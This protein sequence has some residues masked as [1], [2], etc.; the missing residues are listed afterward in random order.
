MRFETTVITVVFT[1][2][3]CPGPRELRCY[4]IDKL[5]PIGE[6]RIYKRASLV[7]SFAIADAAPLPL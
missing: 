5:D 2:G 4:D 1:L 3:R 6:T 7:V